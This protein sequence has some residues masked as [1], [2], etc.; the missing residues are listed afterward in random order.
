MSRYRDVTAPFIARLSRSSVCFGVLMSPQITAVAA[1]GSRKVI[2]HFFHLIAYGWED[3]RYESSLL[4][5]ISLH[6]CVVC[7]S[8]HVSTQVPAGQH[9]RVVVRGAAQRLGPSEGPVWDGSPRNGPRVVLQARLTSKAAWWGGLHEIINKVYSDLM[10]EC[11]KA[12]TF[13]GLFG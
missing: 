9:E 13:M 8:P 6:R 2:H 12:R 5:G 1:K 3:S 10:L 7:A 11:C 4:L